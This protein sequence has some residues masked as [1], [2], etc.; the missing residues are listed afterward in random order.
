MAGA[1]SSRFLWA[2]ASTCACVRAGSGT[3]RN[4]AESHRRPGAAAHRFCASI[5]ALPPFLTSLVRAMAPGCCWRAA[6]WRRRSRGLLQGLGSAIQGLMIRSNGWAQRHQSCILIRAQTFGAS[7]Q[8][9]RGFR[10]PAHCPDRPV[11]TLAASQRR[12]RSQKRAGSSDCA[13]LG[14]P[15]S[16]RLVNPRCAPVSLMEL[17]GCWAGAGKHGQRILASWLCACPPPPPLP[18]ACRSDCGLA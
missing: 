6:R 5:G 12:H 11:S 8:G 3:C 2:G 14:Q 18:P 16:G 1:G 9:N 10:L 7:Q 15:R 4:N 13:Q 17:Q